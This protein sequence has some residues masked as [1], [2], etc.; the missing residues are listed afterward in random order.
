M[1]KFLKCHEAYVLMIIIVFSIVISL[2]NPNFFSLEN[3]FDLLK[4]NA[5]LGI[6]AI[7]VLLVLVSGGID[8]SFAAIATI[9]EYVSVSICIK[10]GGSM[11]S[12][13]LL[14]I[15]I[16]ILLGSIN[17][18]LIHMFE[19][20][21]IIAT[22]ATMNVYYGLLIVVTRGRWIYALPGF[23]RSFAEVRV[24]T[25]ISSTQTPYGISVITVIWFLLMVATA[26]L[27]KYTRLGRSVYAVGG[28]LVSAG[29]IG[30]NV[31]L[32]QVFVYAFMGVMAAIAGIV[33]ALLVQTVAPN[34]IVGKELSVIAAVVLG[35]ASLSGGRGSV[36]GTF[37][38]VMLL[39]I[40]QNGMTLMKV[41]A[42]WY[43]VFVGIVIIVSVGFSS[44]RQKNKKS[45]AHIDIREEDAALVECAGAMSQGGR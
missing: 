20:P 32:V 42:V 18:L 40:V 21:P 4:S 43:D 11:T 27:L 44:Y 13:F 28:D 34:S 36:L 24:L 29:R 35:G 31:R 39:A 14:A 9:A 37:F 17:G 41:S 3:L 22:I 25:L 5:F 2:V 38:G 16:G 6:M 1:K 33:Q 12:A 30:I 8:M 10:L 45:G 19:I 26:L 23:F 15:A 7:G